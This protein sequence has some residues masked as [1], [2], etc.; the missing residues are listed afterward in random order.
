MKRPLCI[1]SLIITAIVFIYLEIYLS[2][3]ICPLPEVTDAA[4]TEIVGVVAEKEIKKG[5]SGDEQVVIYLIPNTK[6][7]GNFRYLECYLETGGYIPSVGETILIKGKIK[8]FSAP[9]NPGEF[10]SRMYYSTLKIAYRIQNARILK[11]GGKRDVYKESLFYIKRYLEKTLDSIMTSEDASVM[12][13]ILLGDKSY[14]DE[15]VKDLYKTNGIMHIMAVS[16]LHISFLGMGLYKLLK[17]LKCNKLLS[18]IVPITVM[19]SYGAM[20]GMGTSAFR[21]ICMFALKI[22][23]PYVGRTYDILTSLALVEILLLIDQPLYLYSSGFLFSFGAV[24]GV[25]VVRPLIRPYGFKTK[26]KKMK[27]ADDEVKKSDAIFQKLGDGLASSL[28]IFLVTLPVYATFYYT[29]PLHSILINLL[30]IPLV[31]V[32]MALG[33]LSIVVGMISS[34]IGQA[35]AALVHIILLLY[36]VLCSQTGIKR[37]LTWYMGHSDKWQVVIYLALLITFIVVSW[38]YSDR[39]SARIDI[40]R[41]GLVFSAIIVLTFH[42]HNYLEIDMVDVGQGDG[43]VIS[44]NDKNLLIDGGSTSK[45]NVGKYQ[46]IPFLKYMGIGRLDAVVM[47]HEDEDHLSGILEIMD[48]METGGIRIKEL[49]M[50]EIADESKGDNYRKLE[51]RAME[52]G[53][54]T[55]YIRLGEQLRIGNAEFICLNP[56]EEMNVSGANEYSTVL[57]MKYGQFKALFT[58][59]VE[60]Q[61]Q[62]N[63][64]RVIRE[65]PGEYSNITLLKVAH[66]GSMY[67]TDQEFLDNISP[68]IALI[69]CGENNSYGHP[70]SE[71]LQRLDEVGACVYRTDLN[72]EISVIVRKNSVRVRPMKQSTSL[73]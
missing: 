59:D 36:K 33:V 57:Y 43:I 13:A 66:H 60:G 8:T 24:I 70:H 29:Y 5:Y 2:E 15:E 17:K 9:T 47:T 7:N 45:K 11:A 69:S 54:P 67:T 42:P 72:G 39:K 63:L 61:G 37:R 32:L 16:G 73:Y 18:L 46:I 3:L 38:K 1:V 55:F 28:S 34:V 64:K 51:N 68:Q 35:P 41:I 50:P 56:T 14:M 40:L 65:N 48:D 31:G 19:S 27:F 58:G 23:A 71:L 20:C 52:L 10:D 12:K 22:F 44:C 53:I 26:Q 62:E 49:I 4:S 30:V 6:L 21:A 25:T